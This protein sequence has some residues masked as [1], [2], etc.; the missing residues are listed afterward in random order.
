MI[1]LIEDHLD[2][3]LALQKLLHIGGNQTIAVGTL[4]AARA[5]LATQSFELIIC[6]ILLPDG[7]GREFMR[8]VRARITCPAI[9]MTASVHGSEQDECLSAGFDGCLPKPVQFDRVLKVIADLKASRPPPASTGDGWQ[10]M[11]SQ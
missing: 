2:T 6:D 5:L 7:N 8:E 11:K 1:L 3:A 4:A 9:A 10:P